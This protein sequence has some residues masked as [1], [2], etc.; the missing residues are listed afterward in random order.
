MIAIT[1]C[2]S[3][4]T[5]TNDFHLGKA[6]IADQIHATV[7]FIVMLTTCRTPLKIN[8]AP[9]QQPWYIIVDPNHLHIC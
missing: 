7:C 6:V 2:M 5:P 8:R 4:A 9:S 1:C 3:M